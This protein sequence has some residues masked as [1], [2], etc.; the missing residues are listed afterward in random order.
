MA[1]LSRLP[2]CWGNGGPQLPISSRGW[3]IHRRGGTALRERQDWVRPT[4]G[5]CEA[6]DDC[7]TDVCFGDEPVA[8]DLRAELRAVGAGDEDDDGRVGGPRSP[9]PA[10]AAATSPHNIRPGPART[11][12]RG[13]FERV[14]SAVRS[15][16]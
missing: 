10:A 1:S 7:R 3:G 15:A 8:V 5:A 4:P 14:A 6:G 13:P 16:R 2:I 12:P 11:G 9:C